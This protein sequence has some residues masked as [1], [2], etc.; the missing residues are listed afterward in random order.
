M[1]KKGWIAFCLLAV[2]SLGLLA[3]AVLAEETVFFTAVNNTLLEL[4]AETMPMVHS[5][6]IY[7]PC[8]VFN[9]RAL[10]TWSYYSRGS[11]TV[12]ISDGEKEL[13]F[14]MSAGN[15][16]D[17]EENTYRYAAVYANDTA[18]V[19]AFFVA[20]F[21]GLGYSYI[22][23]EDRHIV[24]ITKGSVLS[25]E[26]FFNAAASLMETR[27]NQYL[28]AQETPAPPPVPTAAPTPPPVTPTPRGDRSDVS[29]R[30]GFLGL[31]EESIGILEALEGTPACF[32]ATAQ[33]LY[34]HADLARRILGEGCSLGVRLLEDPETELEA[35]R[36]ALRDTT[37][38]VSFLGA[39]MGPAEELPRAEGLRLFTAAEP[40]VTA[41]ACAWTLEAASGSCDLLLI[42]DFAETD[43]LLRQLTRD[44]YTL[45]AV[46]EVTAGR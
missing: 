40:L 9:T 38:S 34:D 28:G 36:R 21:F 42:G 14:D 23:R 39:A 35:F 33:E 10:D 30:L 46:T 5:S 31:G 6:M 8:S 15:S 37:M 32:F 22:R 18:Y 44:H 20:D 4:T 17:R 19:P 7:V 13:Y 41:R 2:L 25:D 43:I 3:P 45:E 27:L 16:Y 24:R 12:L 29:V 1:N 26:D 11:Q